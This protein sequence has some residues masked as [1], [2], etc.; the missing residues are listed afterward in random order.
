[1][2]PSLRPLRHL[3]TWSHVKAS[4]TASCWHLPGTTT[5]EEKRPLGQGT[6]NAQSPHVLCIRD[7]KIYNNNKN[8]ICLSTTAQSV[9]GTTL[10]FFFFFWEKEILLVHSRNFNMSVMAQVQGS[11]ICGWTQILEQSKYFT[12]WV[13]PTCWPPLKHWLH[14]TGLNLLTRPSSTLFWKFHVAQVWCLVTINEWSYSV[15]LYWED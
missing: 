13:L 14:H 10:G 1:M 3:M 8:H 11:H 4:G 15:K 7:L 12:P 2:L 9:A 5:L 6:R